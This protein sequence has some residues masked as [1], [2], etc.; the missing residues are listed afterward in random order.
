M[1]CTVFEIQRIDHLLF[2]YL[3]PL[4][5]YSTLYLIKSCIFRASIFKQVNVDVM[6]ES[7]SVVI[8]G[9]PNIL[10]SCAPKMSVTP[11]ILFIIN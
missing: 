2:L 10:L 6:T 4:K 8:D 11:T 1:E 7:P 5:I 3:F 9:D